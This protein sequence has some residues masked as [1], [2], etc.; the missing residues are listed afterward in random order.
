MTKDLADEALM[1]RYKNNGDTG[2]FE[3]LYTRHKG[4][5]YRYFLRQCG[6]ADIAQ[7][8]FQD[9]WLNLV[10]S[11]QRYEHKAK[12][13][14]LLY[15]MAHNRL[16]DHYRKQS[17]VPKSYDDNDSNAVEAIADDMKDNPESINSRQ[18]M[19]NELL[20]QI[21]LLPEAQREAFLLKEEGGFSV[22]E[23]ANIMGVGAETAKSRLRYASKK[24]R[25]AL[26]G[27]R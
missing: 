20:Q 5:L 21:N 13:T 23:I 4:H 15:R 12:F 6:Q 2:A 16:I 24:L 17:H 7:E 3:E 11:H 22:E 27:L 1:L 8:L 25:S 26:G 9:I 18:E 19:I 10:K 14:T